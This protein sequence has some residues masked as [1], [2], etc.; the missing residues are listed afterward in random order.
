MAAFT[1]IELMV[2]LGIIGLLA[3]LL[4][5]AMH[6]GKESAQS[7]LCKGNLRQL[8]AAMTLYVQEARK[9]QGF[10]TFFNLD[11][12]HTGTWSFNP[13]IQRWLPYLSGNHRVFYCPA[14]RPLSIPVVYPMLTTNGMSTDAPLSYGWNA[15]GTGA[16]LPPRRDLGLGP[17][18]KE[19]GLCVT[20]SEGRVVA[21]AQMIA[22]TDNYSGTHNDCIVSP[23]NP[24]ESFQV[25]DRHSH[26]S[27]IGFCDAHVEYQKK[28]ALT[29]PTEDSR[30]RWNT[31]HLPHRET[32]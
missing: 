8:G 4:L 19:G 22:I 17:R 11:E 14:Q 31:D 16:G 15:M 6:R 25:G 20:I 29:A 1:L 9:Y 24:Y 32:W 27:N 13:G 2:V 12:L 30:Q 21:P 26:G 28:T 7:A 23:N 3:A 18:W 5:P 10:Y